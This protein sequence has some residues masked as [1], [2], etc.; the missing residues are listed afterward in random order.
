MKQQQQSTTSILPFVSFLTNMSP[1]FDILNR[2][3][4]ISLFYFYKV[5]HIY[6]VSDLRQFLC[7]SVPEIIQLQDRFGSFG[8]SIILGCRVVCE[9][10]SF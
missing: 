2:H 9:R 10:L 3:F 5:Y 4:S 7:E 1:N 8:H 6:T